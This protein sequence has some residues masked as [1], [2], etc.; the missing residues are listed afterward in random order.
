MTTFKDCSNK[1]QYH[2]VELGTTKPTYTAIAKNEKQ[3]MKIMREFLKK[4]GKENIELV[5][6]LEI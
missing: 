5:R 2:W 3:A 1:Y 6:I 4:I